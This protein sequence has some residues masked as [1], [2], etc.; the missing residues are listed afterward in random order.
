MALSDHP[1]PFCEAYNPPPIVPLILHF[2]SPSDLS[3]PEGF[4]Y[5]LLPDVT[6]GSFAAARAFFL[7]HGHQLECSDLVAFF[8]ASPG[9]IVCPILTFPTLVLSEGG[10][11]LI[12][13]AVARLTSLV[14]GIALGDG[15]TT[16]VPW[17]FLN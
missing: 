10:Q 17:L 4:Y 6:C 16:I 12:D 8:A 15:P 11:I 2:S 9:T 7:A 13:Q 3:E 5:G 1:P 14:N